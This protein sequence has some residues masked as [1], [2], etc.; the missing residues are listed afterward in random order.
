MERTR[1]V[2]LG[3]LPVVGSVVTS[4][5]VN[6]PNCMRASCGCCVPVPPT[7]H[8]RFFLGR[9]FPAANRSPA[10][11]QAAEPS[12]ATARIPEEAASTPPAHRGQG[13]GQPG[14]VQR[15]QLQLEPDVLV[16]DRQPARAGGR[17]AQLPWPI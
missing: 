15:V 6:T 13:P 16:G 1:S 17:A 8:I 5:T 12:R 14:A 4:L 2:S 10:R 7:L 9:L 11:S 3:V